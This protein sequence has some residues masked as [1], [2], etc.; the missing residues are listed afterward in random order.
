MTSLMCVFTSAPCYPY[1]GALF[2]L[3]LVYIKLEMGN[4]Y[5]GKKIHVSPSPPL[6]LDQLKKNNQRMTVLIYKWCH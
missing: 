5:F 1:V 6:F 2:I 4:V 3:V